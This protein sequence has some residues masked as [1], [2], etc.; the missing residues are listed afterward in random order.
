MP[1]ND[2]REQLRRTRL[3][4]GITIKPRLCTSLPLKPAK[5][6]RSLIVMIEARDSWS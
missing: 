2:Q 5:I 4:P 6:L 3:R 1:D